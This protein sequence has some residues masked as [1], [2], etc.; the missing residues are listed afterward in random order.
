M[1]KSKEIKKKVAVVLNTVNFGGVAKSLISFLNLVK[2]DCDIDL[3]LFRDDGDLIDQ[4][5]RD[6]NLI[7]PKGYMESCG[8]EDTM[9]NL[10]K[11]KKH[12]LFKFFRKCVCHFTHNYRIFAK[13]AAKHSEKFKGYDVAISYTKVCPNDDCWCGAAE[14]TLNNI[15]AK[16][17]YILNHDD[18][19]VK[20]FSKSCMKLIKKFGKMFVV[21]KGCM[22][23]VLSKEPTLKNKID[24]MY[25][26]IDI[27]E[28]LNKSTEKT[29]ITLDKSK[30]QI[31][32]TG[33]I[34]EQKN[35]LKLIEIVSNVKNHVSKNFTLNI[36]G[37]GGL[38]ASLEDKVKELNLIGTVKIWGFQKN[39]YLI[40]RQCD[41]FV[42]NSIWESFGIVYIESMLLG[43]PVL[44][45]NVT[46]A[47]EIIGEYGIVTENEKS[48]EEELIKLIS[49][50]S[51][52][53]KFKNKVSDY[54]FDN[55]LIKDKWLKY[56]NEV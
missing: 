48:F 44:T 35:H 55:Q 30:I 7:I 28:I 21:S 25:N 56:I 50:P 18:Y 17:K 31:V 5:P 29:K 20:N 49:D 27:D 3:F 12:R 10:R 38:R 45:N 22:D 42:L 39:P 14:F 40:M 32:I 9:P 24:Y 23:I 13:F 16:K 47:K 2:N 6:V 11:E 15:E 19:E 54:K 8:Y 52:L 46:P 1:E 34:E 4:I 33:R 36:I 37:D 43:V 53:N 41:L 26:P 51:Y